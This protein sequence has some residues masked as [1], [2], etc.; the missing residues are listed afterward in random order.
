MDSFLMELIV[1]SLVLE[2]RKAV[3]VCGPLCARVVG[4]RSQNM[5]FGPKRLHGLLFA[6]AL[7]AWNT[8]LSILHM[9]GAAVEVRL[10]LLF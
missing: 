2:G 1:H 10:Q 5:R 6:A 3:P 4:Y 7:S 9:Q 8:A